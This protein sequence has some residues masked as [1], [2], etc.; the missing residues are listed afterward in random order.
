MRCFTKALQTIRRMALSPLFLFVLLVTINIPSYQFLSQAE[1]EVEHD[2]IVPVIKVT[3]AP[4]TSLSARTVESFDKKK[5]WDELANRFMERWTAGKSVRVMEF[6][7]THG[8]QHRE[9]YLM[10]CLPTR[11]LSDLLDH[12]RVFEP[13]F[14]K[15][16]KIRSTK[17]KEIASP[18]RKTTNRYFL[19]ADCQWEKATARARFLFDEKGGYETISG[20][21]LLQDRKGP[22]LPDAP[23]TGY[24]LGEAMMRL[25]GFPDADQ[26]KTCRTPGGRLQKVK[27][28]SSNLWIPVRVHL[29]VP[30]NDLPQNWRVKWWYDPRTSL[31]ASQ[32]QIVIVDGK[33]WTRYYDPAG[34][35]E[36]YRNHSV[37]EATP[38]EYR[39]SIEIPQEQLINEEEN[40]NLVEDTKQTS[41]GFTVF[42][43][44][45][46]IDAST[47]ALDIEVTIP[48]SI[49]KHRDEILKK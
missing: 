5:T 31:L 44:V 49:Q 12:A 36:H 18:D 10:P 3:K 38:G 39:L 4:G 45:I 26:I 48:A 28:W 2:R 34:C 35:E 11:C 32:G 9:H 42:S 46:S 33:R 19:E 1:S 30:P 13:K 20:V 27:G 40:D 16:V 43:E 25:A 37:F 8:R 24:I 17:V 23:S 22:P 6:T 41:R 21:W 29:V 7:D 47:G 15:F 14:G